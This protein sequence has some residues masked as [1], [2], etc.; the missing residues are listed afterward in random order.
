M[1]TDEDE[2]PEVGNEYLLIYDPLYGF[3]VQ[4]EEEFGVLVIELRI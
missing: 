3:V 2:V 4:C 1:G